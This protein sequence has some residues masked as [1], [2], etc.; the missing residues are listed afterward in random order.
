MTGKSG[1][2]RTPEGSAGVVTADPAEAS[3][4]QGS[5]CAGPVA[6]TAALLAEVLAGVVGVEQVEVESHFFHDLGADSMVMARFCARVR[7]RRSCRRCP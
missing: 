1:G 7:K 3:A 5:A 6:D 2:V 4:I